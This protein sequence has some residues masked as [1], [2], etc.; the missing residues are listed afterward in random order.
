MLAV[1]TDGIVAPRM[2]GLLST[3]ASRAWL[4]VAVVGVAV[5]AAVVALQLAP[6]LGAGQEVVDAAQPLMT[7]EA[8]AGAVGG[9]ALVSQLVDL[10]DPLMT[11]RGR[12]RAELGR[13][14]T[15]LKR[16]TGVS[17]ERARAILRREAPHLE[18]LLRAAPLSGVAAERSRLTSYLSTT[19]NTSP[20]ALEGELA[21]GFPRIYQLLS[22]LTGV[23]SGWYDVPGVDGLTRFDGTR[24][25]S[26]PE[27]REYLRDDLMGAVSRERERFQALAGSGGI[28]YVGWLLLVVG[29]GLAAFGFVHAHWSATHPSGRFAWGTVVAVGVVLMLVVGALQYFPRLTGAATTIE[30]FEPAFAEQRVAGL[31]AGTDF[32]V[33]TVRFADPLMTSSG[34]AAE[35]PG[36]VTFISG[37]AGLSER[38]VRGQLRRAVPRTM[39]LF[40]AVPLNEAGAEV[41]QLLAVLARKL[42]LG[43]DGVVRSLRRRTPGLARAISAAG[44]ATLGWNAIPGTEGLTR[45]GLGTPVRTAPR[46][47]AYLDVDVVPVF[48]AQRESF[49]TL[50]GGWPPVAALP[51]AVLGLGALLAIYA[52]AMLFLAAPP[53]RRA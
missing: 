24:V 18:A 15:M 3:T 12:S 49:D 30:R 33:Q 53:A 41:P 52:A 13:L 37:R 21:R 26:M 27:V 1:A 16:R 40:E 44:P 48:E 50:A 28:G 31:R 6:R 42:R 51:A 10:A 8:V 20:E 19:L 11:S 34:V 43:G 22:E 45:L 17:A 7:D 14:V 32:V 2:R 47:A 39:A 36:L 46:F 23:V 25:R 35:V 4:G 9:T 29:I 5:A 38:A